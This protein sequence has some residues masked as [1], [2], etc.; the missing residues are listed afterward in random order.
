ML[1]E[2]IEIKCMSGICNGELTQRSE[3]IAGHGVAP[4]IGN[5]MPQRMR[6]CGQSTQGQ[7]GLVIGDF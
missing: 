1:S 5:L 4:A 2:T 6:L 3:G 7:G